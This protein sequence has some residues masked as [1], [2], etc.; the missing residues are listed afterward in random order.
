MAYRFFILL[1]IVCV[2]R[3]SLFAKHVPV[4]LELSADQTVLHNGQNQ[5]HLAKINFKKMNGRYLTLQELKLSWHGPHMSHLFGC[6]YAQKKGAYT[7]LP[8]DDYFVS[9]SQWNTKEQKLLFSFARPLLVDE[10]TTLYITLNCR[11]AKTLCMNNGMFTVDTQSLP[12]SIGND[13]QTA[14]TFVCAHNQ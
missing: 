3:L 10:H 5:T 14:G 4:T 8:I 2:S 11:S 13:I 9:D 1:C 6:L 7:F 12:C